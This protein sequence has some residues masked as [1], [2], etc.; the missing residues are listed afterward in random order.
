MWVISIVQAL[1]GWGSGVQ[2]QPD[3]HGKSLSQT[4]SHKQ[5]E[6]LEEPA[7]SPNIIRTSRLFHTVQSDS[8]CSSFV[9]RHVYFHILS[10]LGKN[11]KRATFSHLS[12]YRGKVVE[13][14]KWIHFSPF[15]LFRG[16]KNEIGS[17]PVSV[18]VPQ[19]CPKNRNEVLQGTLSKNS[20][21]EGKAKKW[22]LMDFICLKEV[23]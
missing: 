5:A 19:F 14:R 21:S 2:D 1:G 12:V 16:R 23:A 11:L 20:S 7:H 8:P 10:R 22:T 9:R 6:I 13:E 17:L 18:S 3:I 15:A 4:H